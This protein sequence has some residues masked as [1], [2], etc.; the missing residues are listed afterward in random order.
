M[1]SAPDAL[2]TVAMMSVSRVRMELRASHG[3]E[4][5]VLGKNALRH[6]SNFQRYHGDNFFRDV[7]PY[8]SRD[9]YTQRVAA[10]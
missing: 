7:L 6:V 3:I 4:E 2:V 10:I 9:R 5:I 8:E 1:T